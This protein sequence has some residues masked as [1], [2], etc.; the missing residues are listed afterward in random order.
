MPELSVD[1]RRVRVP[2][3]ATLLA[4]ARE[5]GIEVPT[6]CFLEGLEH[7]T[8]CMVCLVEDQDSG[9]LLPAC[10]TP[11][12]DGQ[13]VRTDSERAR[14]GQRASLE[15]LL[16]EH[17][18]DCEAPCARACPA[19][20]DIPRAI[21]RLLAGDRRGALGALLETLPLAW[22]LAHVCPAPC[23]RSCRRKLLD[24]PIGIRA[25]KRAAAEEGLVAGA[26][27]VL[28]TPGAAPP[29]GKRV[30]IVGAGPAGLTA[31]YFLARAGHCC[32][33]RDERSDPGGGLLQAGVPPGVLAADVAL[34]ERLGVQFVM[35]RKVGSGRELEDLRSGHD[36]L[37]LATGSADS[38][39]A[40]V[41]A[42]RSAGLASGVFAAGARDRPS[43]L[44]VRAV[45]DGRQAAN[46]AGLFLAGLPAGPLPRRFD[47]HLGV[48]SA[49]ELAAMEAR[50]RRRI[51]PGAA[52]LPDEIAGEACRCLHCDCAKKDSCRLRELAE[53]LSAD[54]RRF[55]G[56]RPRAGGPAEASGG[57]PAGT[58]TAD[59]PRAAAGS[60][61]AAPAEGL[62][63]E[64]GKCIRCGICVRIAERAADRPGL[65]FLGRGFDMLVAVPFNEEVQ[66]AL[67]ATARE[68]A[69]RCPT[70]ALVWRR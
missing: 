33:V 61:R 63:F 3:G 37:V 13:G 43:R 6:L 8:S 69:A 66:A 52:E 23:E 47:S 44:A 2:A 64:P 55:P 16:G 60:P 22:T 30:A 21:R 28:F 50:A 15:L 12:A 31:A 59:S 57:G 11:A 14:A 45:A 9:A 39:A 7:H 58:A 54:A 18:G 53:R 49:G 1:G 10:A 24:S 38:L 34:L 36:A 65:V 17:A 35:G 5:L 4:A 68:C 62:S 25:L 40:L 48:P 41:P 29:T 20:A 56:E 26:G 70:G 19:H 51:W 42:Y 32:L 27:G 46:A 67:P